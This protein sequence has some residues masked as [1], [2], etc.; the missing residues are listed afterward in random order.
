M[1]DA[2]LAVT[3]LNDR[4]SLFGV[5]DGHGG[6][7]VAKF[8]ERHFPRVLLKMLEQFP[9]NPEKALNDAFL[10]MDELLQDPKH[11]RELYRLK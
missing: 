11:K 8:C 10:Q 5:F 1:E 3:D 7:E 6:L 2:H 4:Y 9:D